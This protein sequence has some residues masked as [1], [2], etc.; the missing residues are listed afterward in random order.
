MLNAS[1]RIFR[2]DGSFKYIGAVHNQ[3]VFKE[4]ILYTKVSLWHY[5]YIVLDK[6]L[7]EKVY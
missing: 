2:N 1:P 7:M 3:P 4:P 5:G 6:A